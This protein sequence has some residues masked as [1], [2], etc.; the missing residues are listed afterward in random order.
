[1]NSEEIWMQQLREDY[2]FIMERENLMTFE[3]Y[4]EMR[5]RQMKAKR[6]NEEA[7]NTDVFP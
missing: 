7:G 5:V 3:E 2:V 6:A 4:V 1:M